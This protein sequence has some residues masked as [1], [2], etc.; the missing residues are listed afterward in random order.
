MNHKAK[1]IDAVSEFMRRNR[2]RKPRTKNTANEI[3]VRKQ[4]AAYQKFGDFDRWPEIELKGQ[5]YA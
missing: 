5:S 4:V 3:R 1:V 2:R